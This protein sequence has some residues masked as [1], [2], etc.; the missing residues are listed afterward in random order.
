MLVGNLDEEKE[1]E[2]IVSPPSLQRFNAP[3]QPFIAINSPAKKTQQPQPE[4]EERNTSM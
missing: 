2:I 1:N 4:F 3:D